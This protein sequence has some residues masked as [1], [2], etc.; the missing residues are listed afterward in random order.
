VV[1]AEDHLG[2]VTANTALTAPGPYWRGRDLAAERVRRGLL[3]RE[4][5]ARLGVTARQIASIEAAWRP[6][7]T[8]AARYLAVLDE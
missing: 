6:S 2:V 4:I 1:L 8:A 3:Q 7:P 5:A